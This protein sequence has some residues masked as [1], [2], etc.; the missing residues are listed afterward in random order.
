MDT[1]AAARLVAERTTPIKQ[2]GG[3]QKHHRIPTTVS[4]GDQRFICDLANS[5]M[6][7]DLQEVFAAMRKNYGLKRKEISVDGPTEGRGVITTPFF[8]YEIQIQQ[9]ADEPSKVTWTRS[10]TEINEPARI[11]AGPF[12]EV[13]GHQFSVLELETE[14]QLDLE[15][16][17]DHIEDLEVDTVK[18]DYDKDLTWCE[19]QILNSITTVLLQDELIRV[20][21]RQEVAP[22]TLIE[23]FLEIQNQFIDTLNLSGVPFLA[24]SE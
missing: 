8:N 23:S 4:D 18:V 10:I 24:G 12:D 2:L 21:S 11:F 22:Q 14:E 13:F 6:D 1:V 7:D 3:Y 20:I 5:E 16:I 19:I 15:T 9:D 17:V